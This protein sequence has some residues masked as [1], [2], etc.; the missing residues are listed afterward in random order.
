MSPTVLRRDGF[1]FFFYARETN[2]PPHVHVEKGGATA[3]IWLQPVE[4]GRIH[5]FNP[6][7]RRR[8][9]AIIAEHH[10][11]LLESWHDFFGRDPPRDER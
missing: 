11:D 3:K 1:R 10:E 8:I 9:D 6:N 5:G 2:E 7:E 4:I